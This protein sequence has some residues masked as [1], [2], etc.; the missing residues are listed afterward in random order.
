MKQYPVENLRNVCLISHSSAGKTTLA[1]AMLYFTKATDRF[2]KIADG[3][4]V[5]DYDPEEIKRKISISTAIAPVEWKNTKINLIDTPGY[6]DF[7]GEELEGVRAADAAII[8][9]SGKSGPSVGTEIAWRLAA[10]RKLPKVLFVNKMDQE[11]ANFFKV[12]EEC[13]SLFGTSVFPLNIPIVE[14]HKTVGY[15]NLLDGKARK[16]ANGVATEIPVPDSVKDSLAEYQVMI[17][18]AVAETSEE[19]MEKYFAEEPF[20]EEEL[21]AGIKAGILD[22]SIAPML[23]GSCYELAGIEKLLNL[24]VDLFPAPSEATPIL[25]TDGKE[26]KV[27]PS[28]PPSAQVFKTVADPFVGRMS[29]F[30]VITGTFKPDMPVTNTTSGQP[31]K[32]GRI[33][34]MRG[35]KQVEM[36]AIGAGDLGVVTKLVATRTGDTLCGAGAK[37]VYQGL[38]FPKPTLSMAIVPKAKGDEEKISNGITKLMEEDNTVQFEMNSETK[39]QLVSGMGDMHLDVIVSKLK[40]KY[41]TDVELKAPRVAYRETIRKK[42]KVE[43]KH[44]K[45]SG[46]H[47][48]YGHVWIEFEPNDKEEFEFHDQVFGGAVP[49]NFFPAVE[50]GLRDCI[51]HGVLA[52]YPV[53]SLKATIVDGSYHPVDSSEMAFKVAAG[54]AFKNGLPQANPALLEP[55]GHLT[56]RVPDSHMG[57]IIGDLNKRRGRILGMNPSGDGVQEVEAEVPM[58]EMSTYAIDLR[59]I[60]QGRGSFE[61]KF[62]RYEEAPAPVAAKVIEETKK[63]QAEEE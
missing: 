1:E 57:D 23:C 28:A 26:V 50:K 27:D 13:R 18:E 4:T 19:L 56:V 6:L 36:E 17:N 61:L 11:T 41:G 53:V 9:I 5:C 44:K 43:G 39:Q 14:D 37:V 45:Q 59:S 40:S 60:T 46:G 47:G 51:Q 34:M 52:G 15:V 21:S 38:E 55:I 30:K 29:Y 25:T 12:L 58:S 62:E 35:K 63:L 32:I 10:E 31:E 16:F 49:K 48:Q 22:G 33:F 54:L 7:E 2:G 42:V 8:P 24:I 20:T 3:N